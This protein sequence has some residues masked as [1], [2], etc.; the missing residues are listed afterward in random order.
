MELTYFAI[1][2]GYAE[3][4][5]RGLRS[6][7]LTETQYNQMKNC[8]NLAELKTVMIRIRINMVAKDI[9]HKFCQI[10]YHP[11]SATSHPLFRLHK[12]LKEKI[13]PGARMPTYCRT[14]FPLKNTKCAL[15]FSSAERNGRSHPFGGKNITQI[16]F[17]NTFSIPPPS[18]P[19]PK[20]KNKK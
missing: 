19:L 13:S 14:V 12:K 11:F 5:L 20:I 2:D 3:G 17:C 6:T 4:I 1:D 10:F 7:F 16:Q 15:S 18:P 9:I 8:Q